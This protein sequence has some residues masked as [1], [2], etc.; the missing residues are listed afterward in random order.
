MEAAVIAKRSNPVAYLTVYELTLT[1]QG[2]CGKGIVLFN[3]TSE[4]VL[5]MGEKLWTNLKGTQVRL[6]MQSINSQKAG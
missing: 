4:I 6:L 2:F 5:K 1:W 3:Y